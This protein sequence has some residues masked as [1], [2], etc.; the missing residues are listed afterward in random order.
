M[1]ISKYNTGQTSEASNV[2][3]VMYYLQ[4]SKLLY[5]ST[6]EMYLAKKRTNIYLNE[7]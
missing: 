1:D 6:K 3:G 5:F 2:I 4:I 7:C